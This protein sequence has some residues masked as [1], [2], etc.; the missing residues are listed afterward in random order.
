[1]VMAFEVTIDNSRR[2]CAA[3]ESAQQTSNDALLPSESKNVFT[4]SLAQGFSTFFSL[5][6][7]ET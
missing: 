7:P 3:R 1:M 2:N 4:D 6:T 5:S